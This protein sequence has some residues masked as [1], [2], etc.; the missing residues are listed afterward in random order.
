[1]ATLPLLDRDTLFGRLMSKKDNRA[2]FD[3]GTANP[4]W[5]AVFALSRHA[6]QWQ[7]D[8]ACKIL[9]TPQTASLMRERLA[10]REIAVFA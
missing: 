4:K 5:C 3:C 8:I 10:L 2:C 1:M 7:W 6:N 9:R